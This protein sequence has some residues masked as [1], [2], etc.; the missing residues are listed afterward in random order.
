MGRG[1]RAGAMSGIGLGAAGGRR[2]EEAETGGRYVAREAD[3]MGTS[4]I[5]IS[6]RV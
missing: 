6:D 3:N 1:P 5:T 2:G 4:Y